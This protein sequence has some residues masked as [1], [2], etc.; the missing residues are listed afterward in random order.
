MGSRRLRVHLF[1]LAPILTAACA[2]DPGDGPKSDAAPIV[3]FDAGG[4]TGSSGGEPGPDNPPEAAPDDSIPDASTEAS[5]TATG[6]A[7]TTPPAPPC[8]TCKL[9]VNYLT[10]DTAGQAMNQLH[11]ELAIVNLG[12]MPQALSDLTVRYWFTAE[13][14]HSLSMNCDYAGPLLPGSSVVGAFTSLTP[15]SDRPRPPRP[16]RTSRF[17]FQGSAAI[18]AG[19]NTGDIQ[20]RVHDTAFSTVYDVTNDYSFVA[21]DTASNCKANGAPS[22][23]TSVVTLYKNQ[24]LVW[25][26]EPGGA[27]APAG[28][29]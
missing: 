20:L 28:D 27:Q 9:Q 8:P 10:T 5:P 15:T 11:F 19:G 22:C 17:S 12:A 7:S 26:T 14:D 23:P 3:S 16:T 1:G 2:A 29:P 25:G 6:E 4:G 13:G 18:P 21:G 24:V